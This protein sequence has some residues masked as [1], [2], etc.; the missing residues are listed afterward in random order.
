MS[1]YITLVACALLLWAT[2][3]QAQPLTLRGEA[4]CTGS[5]TTCVITVSVTAGDLVV[6]GARERDGNS[7]TGCSGDSS[8]AYTAH[9]NNTSNAGMY[10]KIAASA[11]TAVTCTWGAT[12]TGVAHGVAMVF[13]PNGATITLDQTNT[14]TNT[15]TTSHSA[16]SITTTGSGVITSQHTV[17]SNPTSMTGTAGF[18]GT[19]EAVDRQ[20]VQYK[21][22]S[23]GE[24][25]TS[26]ITTGGSVSGT[27]WNLS[28]L[29]GAGGG[30]GGCTGG[31]MLLGAGKCD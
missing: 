23:V 2:T 19:T 4:N 16:G 13:N 30:G 18:T 25:T 29:D 7:I 21:I 10:Y 31:V 6:I 11:D 22:T 3:A 12:I 8:G 1:R 9:P 27:G 17:T 28:F 26:T 14:A 20:L 15:S 5:G 24:T